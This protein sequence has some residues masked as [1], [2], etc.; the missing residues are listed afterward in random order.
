MLALAI[1]RARQPWNIVFSE[2][3]KTAKLLYLI[4]NTLHFHFGLGLFAKVPLKKCSTKQA[5]PSTEVPLSTK[6]IV[7]QNLRVALTTVLGNFPGGECL[8]S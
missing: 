4:E 7:P 1:G 6:G 3:K 5:R 2:G 8:E